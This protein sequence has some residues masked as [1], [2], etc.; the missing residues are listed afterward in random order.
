MTMERGLVFR[1]TLSRMSHFLSRMSHFLSRMSHLLSRISHFYFAS[2]IFYLASRIFF[3]ISHL[4][5]LC[6]IYLWKFFSS[7]TKSHLECSLHTY[8][9]PYQTSL[10][11]CDRSQ[12]QNKRKQPCRSVSADEATCRRDVSQRFVTSCVSALIA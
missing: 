12:R 10:N 2:R 1:N 5:F 6:R 11:L 8:R 9:L 7:P 4:A 3:F